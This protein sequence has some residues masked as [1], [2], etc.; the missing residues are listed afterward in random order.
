MKKLLGIFL[1]CILGMAVF[2]PQI[3]ECYITLRYKDVP[4]GF[5][6]IKLPADTYIIEY[7]FDEIKDFVPPNEYRSREDMKKSSFSWYQLAINDGNDYRTAWVI[8]FSDAKK[9]KEKEKSY[10]KDL[11]EEKKKEI[12]NTQAIAKEE[13]ERAVKEKQPAKLDLSKIRKIIFSK[14]RWE[15][16]IEILTFSWP[17]VEFPIIE[18]K[19][20]F[21]N[22]MRVAG[23]FYGF[24]L[25][26]Y[27]KG[28]ALE[29]DDKACFVAFVCM[30]SEKDF[31]TKIMDR[32]VRTIKK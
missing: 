28:Y 16:D 13:V 26:A 18:G 29:I 23:N 9:L 12:L 6:N 17:D 20:A 24:F 10:F 3:G 21:S 5:L 22:E 27:A 14:S 32:A 2:S 31:W 4:A 11:T 7:V 25:S 1:A 15:N 19:Q 30:D 8:I